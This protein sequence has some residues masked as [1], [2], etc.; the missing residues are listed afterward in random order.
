MKY[1][2]D[3]EFYEDGSRIHLISIG[4]VCQ[5]GREYYCEN[6]DFDWDI[7]PPDHWIVGNVKPHL[8][9]SGKFASQGEEYKP[10][11]DIAE[12]V[13]RF[14]TL[15]GQDFN[16]ELWGYYS[17]YDHVVLAQLFGR[18]V[19]MPEGVPWFTLDV[20]QRLVEL[21]KRTWNKL[22]LP[23]QASTE[24]HALADAWW[25][26]DAWEYLEDVHMQIISRL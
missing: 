19:D 6:S 23:K 16:N 22:E 7:V 15:E 10:K 12:D 8:H 9:S 21:Q 14:I 11:T 20:K 3:T 5:D 24:H 25:T 26:R 13:R 18:M 2:Y 4:I 17:S 1:W